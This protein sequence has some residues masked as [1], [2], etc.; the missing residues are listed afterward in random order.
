[1]MQ[2][3]AIEPLT[4]AAARTN[5]LGVECLR[6]G[7]LSGALAKFRDALQE[8]KLAFEAEQEEEQ[9]ITDTDSCGNAFN[10]TKTARTSSIKA[11]NEKSS[12][13]ISSSNEDDHFQ[14]AGSSPMSIFQ[15]PI[16]ILSPTSAGRYFCIDTNVD[17]T[18]FSAITIYNMALVCHKLGRQDNAKAILWH[19]ANA[20]YGMCTELLAS[21]VDRAG[22]CAGTTISGVG[23]ALC[24]LMSMAVLNNQAEMYIHALDYQRSIVNLEYL[25]VLSASS[26]S[27]GDETVNKAMQRAKSFFQTSAAKWIHVTDAA[28]AA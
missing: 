1:M 14:K 18:I 7:D 8:S 13:C 5:N 19:R 27:Y 26:S 23:C 25:I 6:L 11:Q 24:D 12:F 9:E 21:V 4:V 15:N 20:L 2:R 3:E 16:R 22:S 28:S 10:E 17:N